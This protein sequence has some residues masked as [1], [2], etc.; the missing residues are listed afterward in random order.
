MSENTTGFPGEEPVKTENSEQ[1]P[2]TSEAGCSAEVSDEAAKWAV[3]EVNKE[4]GSLAIIKMGFRL[5]TEADKWVRENIVS[6]NVLV[7][8]RLGTPKMLVVTSTLKD[9]EL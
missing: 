8:V 7:P 1:V 3:A 4:D 5:L 2:T 6:G 9:A